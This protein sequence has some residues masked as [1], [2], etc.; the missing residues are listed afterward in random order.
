MGSD[1]QTQN[2]KINYY[3][4]LYIV[5][6]FFVAFALAA[7]ADYSACLMVELFL[8]LFLLRVCVV[9]MSRSHRLLSWLF[10]CLAYYMHGDGLGFVRIIGADNRPLHPS[11]E[12][13]RTSLGPFGSCPLVLGM[14]D[15]PL[16]SV[17]GRAIPG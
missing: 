12:R 8:A 5:L 6:S 9:I 13:R 17:I 4:S 2:I 15:N 11:H 14:E 7:Y 16:S 3:M 10:S 1:R